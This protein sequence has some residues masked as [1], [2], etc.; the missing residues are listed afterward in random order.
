MRMGFVALALGLLAGAPAGAVDT[1]ARP[2]PELA[3]A[4][5]LVKEK[6]WDAAIGAL[7]RLTVVEPSADAFNLLAFSQ[8]NMGD[9]RSALENYF[10]ALA[11]DPDHLG[12]LEYLGELYVKTGEMDKARALLARLEQ[13]C[14]AGCEEREDLEKAIKEGK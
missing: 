5:A 7:A 2:G 13:L 12:A 6:R 9:F 14:P 10:R 4:R 3:A 8:R 11:L 1:V